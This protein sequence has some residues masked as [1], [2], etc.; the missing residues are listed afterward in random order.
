MDIYEKINMKFLCLNMP[1]DYIEG[2]EQ[3]PCGPLSL[4]KT[5]LSLF[6]L[7]ERIPF[8][9]RDEGSLGCDTAQLFF[10]IQPGAPDH[11]LPLSPSCPQQGF[12]DLHPRSLLVQTYIK[13]SPFHFPSA[14]NHTHTNCFPVKHPW[15]NHWVVIKFTPLS[16]YTSCRK[17]DPK[18]EPLSKSSHL[19]GGRSFKKKPILFCIDVT[20]TFLLTKW[21]KKNTV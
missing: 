8:A 21:G 16:A 7:W 4:E 13:A 5:W 17:A 12:Q 6:H 14:S 20:G 18:L 1:S 2:R 9:S 10:H 3:M 15:L 19:L 11:V